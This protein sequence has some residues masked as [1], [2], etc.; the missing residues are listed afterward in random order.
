[1]AGF[2]SRPVRRR[3]PI[4]PPA[5]GAEWVFG[6]NTGASLWCFA[7]AGRFVASA[8]VATRTLS[9]RALAD[10]DIWC[11]LTLA[12]TITA[13]QD[14]RWSGYN[15]AMASDSALGANRVGWPADGLLL[16]P[17][18][19]LTS[20][21]SGIDVGDQYSE[22]FLS[23]IEFPQALPEYYMPTPYLFEFSPTEE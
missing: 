1:M 14:R 12:Q 5:A 3:F 7:I 10:T 4:A 13:S 17:G 22:I 2:R 23:A 9:I 11:I 8:V 20:S 16:Q 6:N 21:T 19:V 15:G 18:N